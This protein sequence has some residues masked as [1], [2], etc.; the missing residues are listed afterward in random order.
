MSSFLFNEALTS[1]ERLRLRNEAAARRVGQLGSWFQ[2]RCDAETGSWSSVQCLGTTLEENEVGRALQSQGG[3]GV[4]WCA[5]K[6]GAPIKG[7]LT[8]NTEPS[9]SFRQARRKSFQSADRIMDPVMEELIRQITVVGNDLEESIDVKADLSD[10]D[11]LDEY[12]TAISTVTEKLRTTA[13]TRNI[14]QRHLEVIPHSTTKLI[15]NSTRCLALKKGAPFSVACDNAGGFLPTQCNDEVCWCVD[16]AGNQLPF[17]GTFKI[18]KRKHCV[19]TPIDSVTVQ[20][21]LTHKKGLTFNHL[22]NLLTRE[23]TEILDDA[24][25]NLAV[26]EN[27][28]ESSVFITFDITD[29][30]KI[31]KAF[32]IEEMVKQNQ[33]FLGEGELRPDITMSRFVHHSSELPTPQRS[34]GRTHV[35]IGEN[36]FQTIVFVLTT[37]SAFLVSILVVFIMLKRGSKDKLHQYETN[38]TVPCGGSNDIGMG[39]KF[40]DYSSPIF[41]LSPSPNP[42]DRHN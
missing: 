24:P 5:D 36:T 38:K 18:S 26:R 30:A 31:D 27:D 41:V 19:H 10:D 15:F 20:L 33:F 39:D 37:T 29:D 8:R 40:L 17:S 23:L 6:K 7:S 4:C 11:F 14:A 22:H 34:S 3:V 16:E 21:H 25:S 13:M 32:A 42:N 2:P 12:T 9:C 28:S 35:S 1:C